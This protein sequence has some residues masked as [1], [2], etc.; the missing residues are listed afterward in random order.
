MT[1][2]RVTLPGALIPFGWRAMAQKAAVLLRA[3]EPLGRVAGEA[4]LRLAL[5]SVAQAG[6]AA[7]ELSSPGWRR[8]A[9]RGPLFVLGHQ[10][11]GTTWLHRLLVQDPRL[12]GL[13]LHAQLLPAVSLQRGLAALGRAD[14]QLGGPI[15]RRLSRLEGRL[16]GPLD[17]LHVLRFG[18]VEEDEFV[19]W[20]LFASGMVANDTPRAA[21]SRALDPLRDFEAWPAAMRDSALSYYRAVA[22]K[23]AHL[24]ATPSGPTPWLCAKNPAFTAKVDALRRFFPDA[25]FLFVHRDPLE[26]IPSRLSL[27]R[28]IWRRRIPGFGEMS[29]AQVETFVGDSVRTYRAAA[30]AAPGLPAERVAVVTYEAL[31]ADPQR[32]VGRVFAR[33]GLG[34]PQGDLARAL[35]TPPSG[36]VSKH[37]YDLEAF[38]LDAE[39]LRARLGAAARPP[40]EPRA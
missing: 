22:Q 34:E 37:R 19:L 26:A 11:S 35:A 38:G 5:F 4:A 6:W 30:A 13:P 10:R 16:F 20:G 3:G 33:L 39:Q 1:H 36:R 9:L 40:Q 17:D 18:E 8:A 2:D 14:A 31:R 32:E 24:R 27:A 29:P 7:D 23:A 12:F 15:A 28:A 21:A 25:R